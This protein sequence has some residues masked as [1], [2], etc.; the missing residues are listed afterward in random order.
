MVS[1]LQQPE[2][3]HILLNHFPVVG[4]LISVISLIAAVLLN[5]PAAIFI[6]LGIV[7]LCAFMVWPVSYY[8]EAGY[9]RVYS[10][11]D[12]VGDAY[13]KKHRDLA[14]DWMWLFYLTGAASVIAI[15]SGYKKPNQFRFLSGLV[16]IFALASLVAGAVIA[17]V[18][19]G[20][21]HEEFRRGTPPKE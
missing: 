18:G 7:A 4:L 21:R 14:D 2:Y 8:G 9:D 20:V 17:E 12:R 19:G 16:I 11:A 3:I 6:S 13:L 10:M 5:K 1:L 15:I